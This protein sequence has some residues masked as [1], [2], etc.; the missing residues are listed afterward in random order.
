MATKK[1]KMDDN[2]DWY[3]SWLK[4]N[5]QFLVITEQN[6]KEL[7]DQNSFVNPE[8]HRQ[9]IDAWFNALKEYWQFIPHHVQEK[10]DENYWK[11]IL[12]IYYEATSQLIELWIKRFQERQPIK[13][14][15][16]LYELWLDCCQEVYSKTIKSKTY[17]NIYGE[18]MNTALKYWRRTMPSNE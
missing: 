7:F 5:Q 15:N 3:A 10:I 13:N 17:Q 16:E 18:W 8:N 6:L 11:I 12:K 1:A 9:Q 4:H 14:I 2:F